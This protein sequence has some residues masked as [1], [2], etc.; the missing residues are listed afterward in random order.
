MVPRYL[1]GH[2][3]AYELAVYVALSWR[4]NPRGECFM[5][6]VRIAQ[7]AGCSIATARR[8]LDGLKAKG[9]L[10]WVSKGDRSCNVYRLEVWRSD[11]TER[12]LST[13]FSTSALTDHTVRSHRATE[14]DSK[15][16]TPNSPKPK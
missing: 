16:K 8:A 11:L 9:I 1:R 6:H 10:T 13:E 4:A 2:L 12:T 3:T 5:R 15:N 7:E 14:R